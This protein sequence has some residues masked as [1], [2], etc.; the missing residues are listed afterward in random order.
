[1]SVSIKCLNCDNHCSTPFCPNCGQ[2]IKTHRYGWQ[3]IIHDLPHAIFHLDKGIPYTFYNLIKQPG[4]LSRRYLKGERVKVTEPFLFMF[5]CAG[6]LALVYHS[7]PIIAVKSNNQIL[8]LLENMLEETLQNYKWSFFLAFVTTSIV[9][10]LMFF[11]WKYNFLEY[12]IINAY[13]GGAIASVTLIFYPVIYFYNTVNI[14]GIFT[15]IHIIVFQWIYP[16]WVY[17]RFFEGKNRKY[18]IL[19]F[20]YSILCSIIGT[21]FFICVERLS[22]LYFHI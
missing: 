16:A 13:V 20:L 8:N 15:L 19:F 7:F 6:L 21:L 9:L 17:Y 4:D 10:K 1:M 12:C 3:S 22:Q 5:V 2:D 18:K 14:I 11:K